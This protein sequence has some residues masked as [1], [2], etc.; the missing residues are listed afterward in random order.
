MAD[1]RESLRTTS[2][3]TEMPSYLDLGLIVIILIS[4]LLSMVRGFTR[5]VLAMGSATFRSA[6]VTLRVGQ[7]IPV[8]GLTLRD[9]DTLTEQVRQQVVRM[10]AD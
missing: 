7:P 9:R 6:P 2:E 4:A 5:E 3:V 10:L 8:A 1:E